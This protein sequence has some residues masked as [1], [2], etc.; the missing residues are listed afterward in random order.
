MQRIALVIQYIGTDLHGWQ[1]QPHQRTVQEE[2]ETTISTSLDWA[3]SLGSFSPRR[4]VTPSFLGRR[5]SSRM[6]AIWAV[7]SHRGSGKWV[8]VR[9]DAAASG[10][11]GAGG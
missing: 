4:V 11:A 5:A 9:D 2:I 10:A 1:R 8:S 7:H 6:S 3:L